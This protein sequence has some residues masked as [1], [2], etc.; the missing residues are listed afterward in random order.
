M[1]NV[2]APKATSPPY[3]FLF[4]F[5]SLNRASTN[6]ISHFVTNFH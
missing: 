5:V 3:Q 6:V 2:K 4:I 1:A